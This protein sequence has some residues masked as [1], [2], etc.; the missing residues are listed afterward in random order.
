M[1]NGS[2]SKS[3]TLSLDLEMSKHVFGRTGDIVQIIVQF[4]KN[5]FD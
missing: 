5:S 1:R 3:E 2:T 4:N